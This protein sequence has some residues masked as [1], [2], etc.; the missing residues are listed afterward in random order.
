MFLILL[1]SIPWE[2]VSYSSLPEHPHIIRP[3]K[4]F[5]NI[6]VP[7]FEYKARDAE[8]KQPEVA[9]PNNLLDISSLVNGCIAVLPP[10]RDSVYS[11]FLE[12]RPID[13]KSAVQVTIQLFSAIKELR[14]TDE[15]SVYFLSGDTVWLR[16][17]V[18]SQINIC[19]G[20]IIK[21]TDIPSI[22]QKKGA[23]EDLPPEWT[24]LMS[25][26]KSNF[27]MKFIPRLPGRNSTEATGWSRLTQREVDDLKNK[28]HVWMLGKILQIL[29]KEN[30][31]VM[32]LLR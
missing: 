22:V 10:I 30:A 6:R 2:R 18:D 31:H 21:I 9:Q 3:L 12:N 23:K 14:M 7:S 8:A 26:D 15:S 13:A 28:A 4:V 20:D 17:S 19:L 25:L 24:S 16:R 1:D 5:E 29:T 11:H 32:I 27:V